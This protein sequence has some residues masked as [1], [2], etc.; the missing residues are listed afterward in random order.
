M[1]SKKH[2]VAIALI[3]KRRWRGDVNEELVAEFSRYFAEDN[4]KFDSRRFVDFITNW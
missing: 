3:L 2:Y 4:P 1:L